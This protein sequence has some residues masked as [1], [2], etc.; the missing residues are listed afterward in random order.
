M[1]QEELSEKLGEKISDK[2]YASFLLTMV[3][4]LQHPYAYEVED[5]IKEYRLAIGSSVNE[6]DYIVKPSMG[7]DG[8]YHVTM[9]GNLKT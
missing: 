6:F 8:R 2:S 3:H 5:F 1:S 7:E 4:L 9:N